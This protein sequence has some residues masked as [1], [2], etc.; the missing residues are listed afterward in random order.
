[1]MRIHVFVIMPTE[2]E[3]N[4]A[5]HISSKGKLAKNFGDKILFRKGNPYNTDNKRKCLRPEILNVHKN[6][7]R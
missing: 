7:M 1:M 5:K 2:E 3:E 4:L 6:L